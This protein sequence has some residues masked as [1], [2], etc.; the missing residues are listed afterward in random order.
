MGQKKLGHLPG[1][2]AAVKTR[3]RD[4]G[5]GAGAATVAGVAE[6]G[7]AAL[8]GV[9]DPTRTSRASAATVQ[10]DFIEISL[11]QLSNSQ[12]IVQNMELSCHRPA[13]RQREVP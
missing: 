13:T 5:A 9:N 1:R 10:N 7:S 2:G 11:Q 3:E 8:S 4:S 12:D 6:A